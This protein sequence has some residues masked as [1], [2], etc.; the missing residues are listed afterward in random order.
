MTRISIEIPTQSLDCRSG[1][2][3]ISGEIDLDREKFIRCSTVTYL[4]KEEQ[5]TYPF[6]LT[7]NYGVRLSKEY[8]FTI[9]KA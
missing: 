5:L 8:R 4:G 9:R 6:I 3:K 2:E 1:E 7:L